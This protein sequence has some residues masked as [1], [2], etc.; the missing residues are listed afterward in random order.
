MPLGARKN[1]LEPKEFQ[2]DPENLMVAHNISNH[3]MVRIEVAAFNV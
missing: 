1:L 3:T 2:M